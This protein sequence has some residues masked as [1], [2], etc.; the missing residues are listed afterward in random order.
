MILRYNY[1]KKVMNMNVNLNK[2]IL[3]FNESYH[4]SSI[5]KEIKKY[6][7]LLLN[8][9]NFQSDKKNVLNLVK[10]YNSI[11]NNEEKYKLLSQISSLK[12]KIYSD[13]RVIQIKKLYSQINGVFTEL[14][15]I[16]NNKLDK[17]IEGY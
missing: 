6:E 16:L 11:E 17:E 9:V 8:D 10:K 2:L 4:D 15:T 3:E 13:E 5:Y 7:T 14:N 1:Q 12:S